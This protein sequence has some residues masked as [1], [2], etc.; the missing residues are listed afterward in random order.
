M[1]FDIGFAILQDNYGPKYEY[2]PDYIMEGDKII[3][4]PHVVVVKTRNKF[5]TKKYLLKK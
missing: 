4:K 3:K 2:V 1:I 5:H